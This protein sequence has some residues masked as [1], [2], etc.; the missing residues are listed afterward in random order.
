MEPGSIG[1]HRIYLNWSLTRRKPITEDFPWG[2]L[3]QTWD[4]RVPFLL[5]FLFDFLITLNT[6]TEV[7]KD[8]YLCLFVLS[9]FWCGSLRKLYE[10]PSYTELKIYL[11]TLVFSFF[12]F[13]FVCSFVVWDPSRKYSD[14]TVFWNSS[15]LSL[16]SFSPPFF[17]L[18]S[19][20]TRLQLDFCS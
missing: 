17:V 18:P 1:H 5:T 12:L 8:I 9:L 10:L 4:Q 3:S 15:L 14:G 2:G 11:L 7:I 20:L 13:T 16:D 6:D 19:T